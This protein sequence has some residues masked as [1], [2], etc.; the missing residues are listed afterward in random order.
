MYV[1][2]ST[3]EAVGRLLQDENAA[4][5]YEGAK[6]LVEWLESEETDE[7]QTQ[8]CAA[9]LRGTWS[10]FTS[11]LDAASEYDFD[12]LDSVCWATESLEEGEDEELAL[13]FLED[14]CTVIQFKGGII[15]SDF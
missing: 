7:S 8:F 2:I 3:S 11:A 6:A 12:A 5:T 1:N 9:T 4:W 14:H 13:Q 10:Q 15:I